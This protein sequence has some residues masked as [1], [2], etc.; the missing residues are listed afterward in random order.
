MMRSVVVWMLTAAVLAGLLVGCEDQ[1]K[2]E[3]VAQAPVQ[4]PPPP[5]FPEA[6]V[7]APEPQPQATTA[8]PPPQ[9]PPVDTAA[10]RTEPAPT[11]TVQPLP[12]ESYA[13]AEPKPARTYVVKKGDTL[14]KISRR[15]YGTT[16]KWR[17]IYNANRNT[18]AKGPD[19]LSIGMKLI[20]P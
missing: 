8:S 14:Q 1:R 17:A 18:L 13:P 5:M 10:T 7:P 9:A 19:H 15:F 6:Q 12:K 16:R 2:E 4:A 20:I 3:P 11:P